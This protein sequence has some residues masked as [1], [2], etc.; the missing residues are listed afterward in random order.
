VPN[1]SDI[2]WSLLALLAVV[3]PLL[4]AGFVLGHGSRRDKSRR[5]RTSR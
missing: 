5:D 3:I 2:G 4:L 1:L